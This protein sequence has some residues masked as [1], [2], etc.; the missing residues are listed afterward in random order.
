VKRSRRPLVCL[1]IPA[2]DRISGLSNRLTILRLGLC[3][4]LTGL[5]RSLGL[6]TGMEGVFL[7]IK[8]I[9]VGGHT[10]RGW[11]GG[12]DWIDLAQNRDRWRALVYTVMNI[13]VP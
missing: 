9:N 13:R 12:A 4:T 2:C 11:V 1:A 10:S 3:I 7:C 6:R 5:C 8:H